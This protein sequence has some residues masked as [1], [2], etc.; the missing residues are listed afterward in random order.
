MLFACALLVVPSVA[1]AQGLPEPSFAPAPS[2][3]DPRGTPGLPQ[4]YR[5][6]TPL[7][8][9]LI[10]AGG[11][12]FALSE[13]TLDSPSN[14]QV[15]GGLLFDQQSRNGFAAKSKAGRDRAD[16]VSDV[17]WAASVGFTVLDFLLLPAL[18]NGLPTARETAVLTLEAYTFTSL[19][20]SLSKN[21][22]AR[23]RPDAA[24][25]AADPNY[26]ASCK[27]NPSA[28]F[29]S[30]HTA[31][32][33][34]GA[35]LVCHGHLRLGLFGNRAADIAACGASLG[36]ASGVG[37]LR[38]NADRHYA[39]DVLAGAA[40]GFASGFLLPELVQFLRPDQEG[41]FTFQVAPLVS[42]LPA[43]TEP[44]RK[45]SV[46]AGALVQGTF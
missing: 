5:S 8:Y 46:A 17:L 42:D 14:P 23:E 16:S 24:A 21:L 40:L 44:G 9:G 4:D 37:A 12:M 28:S 43:G 31:V 35:G 2:A 11:A 20:T 32:A 39:T 45:S 19:V 15:R 7:E 29:P 41:D 26:S 36:I 34:T 10:L 1:R 6:S 22:V 25:C 27:S 33:F 38:V 13:F 30:G 3:G 18:R